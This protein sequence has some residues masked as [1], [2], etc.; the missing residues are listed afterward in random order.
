MLT[1]ILIIVGIIAVKFIYDSIQQSNK[2]QEEGGIR[3]KYATLIEY[4]LSGHPNSRI[5]QQ[6]NTFCAVGVSGVAGSQIYYI[7]QTFG[8][9]TIQMKIKN[10][11]LC[12]N[13]DMEWSFPE[14]MV[15]E[16]MIKKINE[17]IENKMVSLLDRFK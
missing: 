5:F 9:V 2:M 15:Q 8:T 16:Q 4:F 7:Q 6:T 17:D 11:P 1:F 3:K 10:N 14:D 12:G 13:L